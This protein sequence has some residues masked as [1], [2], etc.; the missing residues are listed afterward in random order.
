VERANQIAG[1]TFISYRRTR[2]KEIELLVAA[3]HDRGVP[4]WQDISNLAMGQAEEDLKEALVD[5]LISSA[6]LWITPDV[7]D[8]PIIRK[9]EMP[10]L[11]NRA[12]KEEAFFALLV[13]AGSLDYDG[14]A[15]LGKGHVPFDLGQFNICKLNGDPIEHSEAAQVA[16]R[17]LNQRIEQLHRY[18]HPDAPLFVRIYSFTPAPFQAGTALTID[19]APRFVNGRTALP[20]VWEE[21]LLPA[22]KD[23][24]DTIQEKA[25][26]RAV[27]ITGLLSL[28][29][30]VALGCAFLEPRRIKISWRP[31]QSPDQLWNIDEPRQSSGVVS[32]LTP[33]KLEGEDLAV[34]VSVDN[35]VGPAFTRSKE[36][37]GINFRAISEIFNPS[38]P[39]NVTRHEINSPGEAA[40]IAFIVRQAIITA[41]NQY[42]EIKR[43]HLFMAVPVGLA[44]MIGQLLNTCGMIQTYEFHA[45]NHECP[46]QPVVLLNPGW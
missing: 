18:L 43:A 30:A 10:E 14:V 22:L 8:S 32:S 5:P 15:A 35:R 39:T 24:V 45:D 2:A 1:K 37:L 13:A 29:A 27:E 26:E 41:R 6:I 36:H 25:S 40:D 7:V 42:S 17:V 23:I 31:R 3:L 33:D 16:R 28:P 11:L 46:Y 44:M 20:G 12:R 9:V 38:L 19:W 34:L 4:T 21:N